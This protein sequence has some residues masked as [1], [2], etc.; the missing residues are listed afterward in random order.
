MFLILLGEF[1]KRPGN[2]LTER[3]K[4]NY[5]Y[6]RRP[7]SLPSL[8]KRI[9]G[10][11]NFHS[12]NN[13]K[14]LR[15]SSTSIPHMQEMQT[16]KTNPDS[17]QQPKENFDPDN[18]E[19]STSNIN[20]CTRSSRVITNSCLYNFI[21]L[22][23]ILLNQL[24][25]FWAFKGY[26]G[27]CYRHVNTVLIYMTYLF[28]IDVLVGETNGKLLRKPKCDFFYLRFGIESHFLEFGAGCIKFKI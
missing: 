4:S 28:I 12:C 10:D 7:S 5:K 14:V 11:L 20:N 25:V 13:M 23:L 24:F 17:R 26:K 21:K 16:S 18:F 9:Y 6:K 27:K 2:V 1:S 8:K 22:L 19:S 3:S 15:I